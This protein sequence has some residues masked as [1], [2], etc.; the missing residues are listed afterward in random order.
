M[1]GE[2]E[3]TVAERGRALLAEAPLFPARCVKHEHNDEAEM[4]NVAAAAISSSSEHHAAG[5][6]SHRALFSSAVQVQLRLMKCSA[7][8]F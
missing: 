4:N 8:G 2:D 1:H 6:F 3:A 7:G 5:V